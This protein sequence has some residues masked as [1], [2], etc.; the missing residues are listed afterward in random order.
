L[1][2]N[3]ANQGQS[4]E[5]SLFACIFT[6]APR[7]LPVG[8]LGGGDMVPF[9]HTHKK[10]SCSEAGTVRWPAPE[11]LF[12]GLGTNLFVETQFLREKMVMQGIHLSQSIRSTNLLGLLGRCHRVFNA[13]SFV[14]HAKLCR[15]KFERKFDY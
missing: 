6:P 12:A 10:K 11:L 2:K 7:G 4:R 3:D 13:E 14:A 8:D 5:M 15:N 9:T 1:E